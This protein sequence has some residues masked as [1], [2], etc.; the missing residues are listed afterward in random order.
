MTAIKDLIR[1]GTAQNFKRGSIKRVQSDGT[2]E[3]SWY[4]ISS[5]VLS[6]PVIKKSFGD[7]V[8]LGDY[9]IDG[10]DLRLNNSNRT[11]NN[12]L[13]SGSLFYGY[14]TRYRTKIKI[15]CGFIDD[16]GSEV[17]GLVFYG[18]LYSEPQNSDS[19][20]IVFSIAPM[21]KVFQNYT[22]YGVTVTA[23]S[24]ATMLSRLCT[25]TAGGVR[26]FDRFFEGSNDA[27]RY[28]INPSS[29]SVTTV[30]HPSVQQDATVWDKIKDYSII[31]DFFA[32]VDNTGNLIWDGR[33][34][35]A[36]TKWT[37]NGGNSTDND[38]GI[39]IASV[40][41]ENDGNNNVWPRA[42]I[43]YDSSGS[44][45]VA[46]DS[47]TPGDL[48]YQDI[49]GVRTFSY[50]LL[51]LDNTTAT[52]M[53]T[54]IKNNYKTPK[55]EWWIT[56]VFIPQLELKDKVLINYRGQASGT[57]PWIL[58]SSILGISTYLSRY[59]GSMYLV[60]VSAK[61]IGIELDLNGPFCRFNLREV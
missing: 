19:G 55:R 27:T 29:L 40:D 3:S 53:A 16:D 34:E 36:S 58:G 44:Q 12:E 30:T 31:D 23:A 6:Y 26:I 32:Y 61:I 52:T 2:Y 10:G 21:T 13:T 37:F 7:T 57:N 43:T 33:A 25:L 38:Y 46:S 14:L 20:E 54:T 5:Y 39:N 56:T 45:V 8:F 11:F 9:Q 18:I 59:L 50:E 4:D 24:T 60:N 41:S 49:Y 35:T 42:V 1:R 28:Q 48:S 47:W 51:D 17:Q 15:E 22:A